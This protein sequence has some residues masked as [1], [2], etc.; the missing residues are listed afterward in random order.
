MDRA[1]A[2]VGSADGA[3][4][5]VGAGPV[6]FDDG[7]GSVGFDDGTGWDGFD[8][9]TGRDEGGAVGAGLV[10]AGLVGAELV[11]TGTVGD[12]LVGEIEGAV[13]ASGLP[14]VTGVAGPGTERQSLPTS[15]TTAY[16]QRPAGTPPSV[17]E[18][19]VSTPEQPRSTVTV[20]P[21]AAL[22]RDSR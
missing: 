18:V 14:T 16:A 1:G 21:V 15:A 11:G 9:G 19:S 3:E 4:L 6:G 5:T 2:L 22:I 10:G 20:A 17:H 13:T 7:T 8:D 12:G